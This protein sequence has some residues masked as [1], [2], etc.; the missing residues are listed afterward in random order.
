MPVEWFKNG[1]TLRVHRLHWDGAWKMH[2]QLDIVSTGPRPRLQN[3]VRDMF[4]EDLL[5]VI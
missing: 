2:D 3:Q 5:P 1:E 4:A